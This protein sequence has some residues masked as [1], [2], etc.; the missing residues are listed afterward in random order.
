MANPNAVA[1][2]DEQ[3]ETMML[4]RTADQTSG[5]F[6]I[7][8]YHFRVKL[9]NGMVG[10]RAELKEKITLNRIGENTNM[11]NATT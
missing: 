2:T 9:S 6:Q 7:V 11:N 1:R 4:V 5:S 3:N 8:S 10:K